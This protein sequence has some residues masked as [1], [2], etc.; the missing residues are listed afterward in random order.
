MSSASSVILTFMSRDVKVNFYF[1][2]NYEHSSVVLF[3]CICLVQ[4][5]LSCEI[6]LY[7]DVRLRILCCN[8]K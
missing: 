6:L 1:T 7:R 2:M 8:K 4:S 3:P 5:V